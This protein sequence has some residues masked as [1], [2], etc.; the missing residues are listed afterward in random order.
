MIFAMF[1][2]NPYQFTR[3]AVALDEFAANVKEEVIVQNG[4]TRFNFKHC[5]AR[6]FYP[7]EEIIK[8]ISDASCIIIQGGAGSISD[9]IRLNKPIVVVPRKPELNESPDD[10]ERLVRKLDE[11]G[12][13]TALYDMKDLMAKYQEALLSKYNKPPKNNI[14]NIIRNY[15]ERI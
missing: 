14:P 6:D 5:Q 15:L 4:N 7:H 3:L 1:G 8:L 10:Q 11:M 13:I 2:T 12:C 9:G